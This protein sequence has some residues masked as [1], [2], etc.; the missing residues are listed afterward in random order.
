M[1]GK[2]LT[3]TTG[4]PQGMHTVTACTYVCTYVCML[5]PLRHS[6]DR[7]NYCYFECLY[8]LAYFRVHIYKE[9]VI[10]EIVKLQ[11]IHGLFSM[12]IFPLQIE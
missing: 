12:Y 7:M 6:E 2:I 1:L 8:I 9:N 10:T 5:Q 3:V 11:S 4:T